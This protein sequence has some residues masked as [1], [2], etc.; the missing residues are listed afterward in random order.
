MCWRYFFKKFWFYLVFGCTAAIIPFVYLS[1]ILG[2]PAII[3]SAL[4]IAYVDARQAVRSPIW[5]RA[6]WQAYG[7]LFIIS[8][9]YGAVFFFKRLT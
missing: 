2:S 4:C 7:L 5:T 8:A 1:L 6:A 9:L 3:L